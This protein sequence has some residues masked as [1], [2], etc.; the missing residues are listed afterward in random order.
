MPVPDAGAVLGDVG[1]EVQRVR[2][3]ARR[4]GDVGHVVHEDGLWWGKM[5]K[6][7]TAIFE[8]NVTKSH[9]IVATQQGKGMLYRYSTHIAFGNKH[10][11][12][13]AVCVL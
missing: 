3:P 2:V 5:T 1:D 13:R 7:F 11:G 10:G 9:H 4:E 8:E 12:G 6:C